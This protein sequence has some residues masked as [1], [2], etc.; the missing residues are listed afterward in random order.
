MSFYFSVFSLP[1]V[2]VSLPL[3]IP[4]EDTIA[5]NLK[6]ECGSPQRVVYL[7]A[8][9]LIVRFGATLPCR[10]SLLSF[11]IPLFFSFA[12]TPIKLWENT[13][14]RFFFF[15]CLSVKTSAAASASTL[16]LVLVHFYPLPSWC[17][18]FACHLQIPRWT[19][20]GV[21]RPLFPL[22][23]KLWNTGKALQTMAPE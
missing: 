10:A 15:F 2:L 9:C 13:W 18:L 5:I 14:R 12:R 4:K 17:S 23:H 22:K 3:C 6:C 7:G 8:F 16:T 11:S 20:L 21:E 19:P 1:F